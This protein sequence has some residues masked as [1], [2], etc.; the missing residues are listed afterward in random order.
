MLGAAVACSS[1]GPQLCP[2]AR[3]GPLLAPRPLAPQRAELQGQ[4]AKSLPVGH[5]SDGTWAA[6]LPVWICG[7]HVLPVAP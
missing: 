7:P 3:M 1:V 5:W 2:L 6:G 4:E